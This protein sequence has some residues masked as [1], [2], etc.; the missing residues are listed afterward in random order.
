MKMLVVICPRGRE[1]EVRALLGRH[2]GHAYTEVPDVLGEGVTGKHLG[3]HTFPGTSALL[4]TVVPAAQATE[5]T[6]ALRALK[7]QL[8]PG[9][10]LHAFSVP[11]EAVV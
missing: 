6:D 10:S 9:E 4:F 2:G 3:T 11:V 8:Y 1:A 5:L 7:G